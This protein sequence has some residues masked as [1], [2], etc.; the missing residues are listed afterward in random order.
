MQNKN[1]PIKFYNSVSRERIMIDDKSLHVFVSKYTDDIKKQ[2]DFVGLL[3][4]WVATSLTLLTASF[5]DFGVIKAEVWEAIFWICDVVLLYF[6]LRAA[7]DAWKARK[8][9]PESFVEQIK[10]KSIVTENI[11]ITTTTF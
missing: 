4:A 6:T 2:K 1:I 10:A 5:H 11:D 9:N 7:Y 8:S 3:A